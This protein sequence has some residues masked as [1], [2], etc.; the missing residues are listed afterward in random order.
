MGKKKKRATL[1]V[2]AAPPAVQLRRITFRP[3][4]K[5]QHR[6]F[7]T[8]V[9]DPYDRVVQTEPFRVPNFIDCIVDPRTLAEGRRLEYIHPRLGI[10]GIKWPVAKIEEVQL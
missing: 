1:A 9:I 5:G 7:D 8:W 10:G 4:T 2:N 3:D 6:D